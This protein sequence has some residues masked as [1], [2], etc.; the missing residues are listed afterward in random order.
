MNH[1][2]KCVGRGRIA[3]GTSSGLAV[4]GECGGTT[5]AQSPSR[6][7]PLHR[8]LATDSGLCLWRERGSRLAIELHPCDDAA[9]R[10]GG[11]MDVDKQQCG[12]GDA[13]WNAWFV[14]I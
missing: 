13:V 12:G 9:S 4:A 14:L 6:L 8:Q 11:G 1:D 2:G 3:A 5:P 7:A 10:A